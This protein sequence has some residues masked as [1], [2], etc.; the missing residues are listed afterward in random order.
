MNYCDSVAAES[1]PPSLGPVEAVLSSLR[2]FSDMAPA[3]AVIGAEVPVGAGGLRGIR[4]HLT[5]TILNIE[6]ELATSLLFGSCPSARALSQCAGTPS[7][8]NTQMNEPE[9]AGAAGS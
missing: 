4:L 3:S 8:S 7:C 1:P 6:S 2:G 5:A 9:P